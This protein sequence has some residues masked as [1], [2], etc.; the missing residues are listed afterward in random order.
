M[1][2]NDGDPVPSANLERFGYMHIGDGLE[3]NEAGGFSRCHIDH[4]A[5]AGSPLPYHM[6]PSYWTGFNNGKPASCGRRLDNGLWAHK[7]CYSK[8]WKA[9]SIC[10]DANNNMG[11]DWDGGD[12]CAATA[13]V[14]NTQY[15]SECACIDP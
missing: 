6:L 10:D 4:T 12:C 14:V 9:D 15:C 11:C 2:T 1:G 8:S 7:S 5:T 13:G 3:L